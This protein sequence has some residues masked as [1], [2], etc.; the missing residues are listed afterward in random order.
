MVDRR[1][2]GFVDRFTQ[3]LTSEIPADETR[4]INDEL[5]LSDESQFLVLE[6]TKTQYNQLFDSIMTGADLTYVEDAHG[7]MWPFWRAATVGKFC[8]AVRQ[9]VSSGGQGAGGGG[10]P[11]SPISESVRSADL[12]PDEWTCDKDYAFGMARAIVEHIHSATEEVFQAIE[13]LTNPLELAA[14][15]GDNVPIA[16]AATVGLDIIAWIQDTIYEEY[17]LA[18]SNA[19]RDA[20]ACDLMC[21][22]MEDCSLNFDQVFAL[23]KD[24]GLVDPP[25]EGADFN[26]WIDW[27]VAI[28][29]G[30]NELVVK[31]GGMLGLIAMY[32][33]SAFSGFFRVGVYS[34]QTA[35]VLSSDENSNEWIAL[36]DDC[37]EIPWTATADLTIPAVMPDFLSVQNGVFVPSTGVNALCVGGNDTVA[38]VRLTADGLTNNFFRVGYVNRVLGGNAGAGDTAGFIEGLYEPGAGYKLLLS[39]TF[40]QL[41]IGDAGLEWTG[42]EVLDDMSQASI[43]ADHNGCGGSVTIVEIKVKGVGAH[44]F[45]GAAGW[46]VT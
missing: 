33:G 30:V 2:L 36:C 6:V 40:G 22:I 38:T 28:P 43:R 8:D 32:F 17:V 1:K 5:A 25:G 13:V 24:I 4:S 10:N 39:Q 18:W 21:I 7:V 12:L 34:F 31:A 45:D 3:Y 11:Q 46:V 15:I 27:L 9:C 37:P 29:M 16:S 41:P 35:L 20:I 44:P 26:E 42:S 19:T 14:E 23:Y